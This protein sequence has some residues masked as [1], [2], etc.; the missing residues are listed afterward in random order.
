MRHR[1]GAI[2]RAFVTLE[3]SL[4]YEI[5]R[6]LG[7]EVRQQHL[8]RWPDFFKKMP[9]ND[10]LDAITIAFRLISE[11]DGFPLAHQWAQEIDEI[12]REE[13]VHYRV[14]DRGGVHFR[15]D[16][17][18]ARSTGASVAALQDP[19]YANALHAFEGGQAFLSKAPPDGKGAIRGTFNALEGVFRLMFPSAPRLTMQFVDQHL[20]PV[21]QQ[22]Y[23]GDQAALGAAAKLVSSF[24]D[25]IDA[26]HFYRHEQGKADTV[27]QP[28]LGLAIYLVS[29]GAAHLRWLAEL[30][31]QRGP[32]PSS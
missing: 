20:R 22:I 28:P 25:W 17:E 2:V 7:M 9:L 26:A 6:K 14:D 24:N 30:D 13:N 23:S 3:D 29:G 15:F 18:F 12:F 1:I 4:H 32:V 19:R 27:A 10:V 11:R 5:E 8:T 31:L 16:P 21:I